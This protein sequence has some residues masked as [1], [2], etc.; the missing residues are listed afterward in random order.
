MSLAPEA[1]E[2]NGM[3]PS[4]PAAKMGKRNPGLKLSPQHLQTTS[5]NGSSP[6][7]S[8]ANNNTLREKIGHLMG[9]STTGSSGSLSSNPSTQGSVA[10]YYGGP[11]PAEEETSLAASYLA[12]S[13]QQQQQEHSNPQIAP[14]TLDSNHDIESNTVGFSLRTP[15]ST[16]HSM[17]TKNT[18][19]SLNTNNSSLSPSTQ[20][21]QQSNHD[22]AE[23]DPSIP[24]DVQAKD[25]ELLKRLGEGAAGTVR[26]VYHKPSSLTMAKKVM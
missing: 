13:Q 16:Q 21:H 7:G 24:H 10:S 1:A 19:L 25:L 8:Q 23:L 15:P 3:A 14:N 22:T 26:L 5:T 17:D 18:P 11:P 12:A 4:P 9:S 20:D 6:N 2:L